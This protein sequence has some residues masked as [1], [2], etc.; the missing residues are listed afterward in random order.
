[1]A[2]SNLEKAMALVIGIDIAAPGF[3]R[4]AAKATVAAIGRAGIP[5]AA[6]AATAA[7]AV[8]AY[9]PVTTGTALGLGALATPQGQELLDV[10]EERG[11]MDRVRFEQALTDYTT[12][13]SKKAKKSTSKYNRAVSMGMKAVKK[14]TSYGKKGTINNAKKAF[15]AVNKV[16]SK[17]N[18]GKKVSS[19]G[20]TG[21]IKKAIGKLFPKKKPVRR[22][23]GNKTKWSIQVNR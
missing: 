9:S 6:R 4:S 13:A 22:T 21:V 12:G 20:P 11:R 10:A 7:P 5:L 23:S 14:S 15:S 16:A 2:F 19:K 17:L 3:S 18:R 1:M 8:A